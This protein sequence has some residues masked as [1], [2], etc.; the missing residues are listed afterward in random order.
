[1]DGQNSF[2]FPSSLIFLIIKYGL[3]ILDGH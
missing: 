2:P 1:M 3:H